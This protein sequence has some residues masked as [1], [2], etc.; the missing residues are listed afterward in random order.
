[1]SSDPESVSCESPACR[2]SPFWSNILQGKPLLTGTVCPPGREALGRATWTFLHSASLNYPLKPSPED[3]R[4]MQVF[5]DSFGHVYP[6]RHCAAHYRGL[7][8]ANPP[9]VDNREQL[10]VWVCEIHNSTNE[11]LGKPKFDCNFSALE[12]RWRY[13]PECEDPEL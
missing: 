2:S 11:S 4:S 7:I 9:R 1:M 12:K 8:K 3:K 6:C 5:L 10:A 13:N